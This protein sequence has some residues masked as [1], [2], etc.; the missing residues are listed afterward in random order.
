MGNC[1]EC[2]PGDWAITTEAIV[3]PVSTGVVRVTLPGG[4]R[5]TGYRYEAFDGWGGGDCV[6]D[7]PCKVGDAHWQGHPAT[8]RDGD[9]TTL[10]GTFVNASPARERR[11]RLTAFFQPPRGWKPQ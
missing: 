1:P 8:T 11:A 4:A 2:A 9:R 7:Q 3:A 6:A 10:A 5:F